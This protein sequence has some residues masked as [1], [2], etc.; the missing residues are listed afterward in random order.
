MA[1]W[2]PVLPLELPVV[3][4]NI[5]HIQAGAGIVADSIPEQEWNETMN[6]GR[7]IF[8]AVAMACAG[9]DGVA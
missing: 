8:R 5:L 3:S 7:V 9:L 4:D 1:T 6:K 2:I